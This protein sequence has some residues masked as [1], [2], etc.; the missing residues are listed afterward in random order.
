MFRFSLAIIHDDNMMS[1]ICAILF[2]PCAIR[3]LF[4]NENAIYLAPGQLVLE[5]NVGTIQLWR[6]SKRHPKNGCECC[7]CCKIIITITDAC[8]A[9]IVVVFTSL[10][11]KGNGECFLSFSLHQGYFRWNSNDERGSCTHS[12]VIVE[13]Y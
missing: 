10:L 2:L 7:Y 11:A 5:Y 8:C 3:C 6:D 13:E 4:V 12:S 1:F 9:S